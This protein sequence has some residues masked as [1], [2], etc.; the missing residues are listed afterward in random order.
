MAEGKKS[1]ADTLKTA[2]GEGYAIPK[3]D[4]ERSHVGC[5]VVL[6]C[7]DARRRAE[8]TLLV[9]KETDERTRTGMLRYDVYIEALVEVPYSPP[10]TRLGRTGILVAH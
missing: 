3:A 6:L 9:L 1:F 5:G 7:Q 8:G 4:A 10:P 2:I